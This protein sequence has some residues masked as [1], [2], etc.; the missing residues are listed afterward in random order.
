M[1]RLAPLTSHVQRCTALAIA[2]V[3]A[4]EPFAKSSAEASAP[5]GPWLRY[6]AKPRRPRAMRACST[7]SPVCVSLRDI[8]DAEA[9][10]AA[11]DAFER[12][13]DLLTGALSLPAPDLDPET[14]AY[15]VLLVAPTDELASTY[16]EARDV[17]SSVDR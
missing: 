15:E 4:R 3:L 10:R 17:R 5:S 14:L 2:L 9:G 13:W 16:L 12:A 11:L 6:V 8:H 1:P 7:Q